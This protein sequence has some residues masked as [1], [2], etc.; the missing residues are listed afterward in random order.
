MAS[1]INGIVGG[2][3]PTWR[4]VA[5]GGLGLLLAF[6]GLGGVGVQIGLGFYMPFDI[7]LTYTIGC[8]MRMYVERRKG[9]KFVEDVGIPI[10]AGVIVGEA[11]VGVGNAFYHLLAAGGVG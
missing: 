7:V 6:S 2:D 1:M 3:V 9:A 5:G 11:L 10:A 8:L 4:Y